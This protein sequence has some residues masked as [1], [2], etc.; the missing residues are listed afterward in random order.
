[1]KKLTNRGVAMGTVNGVCIYEMFGKVYV[2]KKS[3]L[4]RK[5][6]LKTK[7]FEKTRKYAS[8]MGRAARIGSD[9]YKAIPMDIK[10][11][12][13]YRAITGEA[14]SL[15]YQGKEEEEVRAFLWKKYIEDTKCVDEETNK[16]MKAG[17]RRYN[18]SFS[19]KESNISLRQIFEERWEKQGM[20][21]YY[22]KRAWQ[23]RGHFSVWRFRDMMNYLGPVWRRAYK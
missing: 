23:K 19:T 7:A 13:I 21:T 4:T 20:S 10:D 3:S 18:V 8:D 12:W 11:R 15:L 9:I 1:M 22:F 6:V 17:E 16:L 5:R 14:A 2:R